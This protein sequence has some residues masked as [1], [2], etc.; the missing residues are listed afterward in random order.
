MDRYYTSIPLAKWLYK[1]NITC[2]GTTQMNRKGLSIEMK[3]TK[4]REKFIWMSCKEDNGPVI[5]NSY[6]V[7][8]KSIGKRNVS[9][10]QTINVASYVTKD[11]K[12]GHDAQAI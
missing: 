8:T 6:V 10:L 4:D 5:L 1:K 7:K 2:I 9:L 3:E 12:K 11:A